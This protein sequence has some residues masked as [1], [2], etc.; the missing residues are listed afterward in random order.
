MMVDGAA[1]KFQS[2]TAWDWQADP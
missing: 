1:G 2:S